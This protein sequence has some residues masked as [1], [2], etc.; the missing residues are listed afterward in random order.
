MNRFA[1]PG[2]KD[3]TLVLRPGEKPLTEIPVNTKLEQAVTRLRQAK[4]EGDIP[5][6]KAAQKQIDLLK[7]KIKAEAQKSNKEQT[8]ISQP[9]KN[10]TAS[11]GSVKIESSSELKAS[12]KNDVVPCDCPDC[13]RGLQKKT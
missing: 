2:L 8:S 4:I 3:R 7:R 1:N 12:A 13:Q 6:Q 11:I 5:A 9:E 10:K